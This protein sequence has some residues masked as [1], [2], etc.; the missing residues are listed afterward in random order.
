MTGTFRWSSRSQAY[1]VGN[2]QIRSADSTPPAEFPVVTVNDLPLP[3][4]V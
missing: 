1:E 4:E 2:D 3:T